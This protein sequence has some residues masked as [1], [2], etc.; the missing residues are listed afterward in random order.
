[1][2]TK[3]TCL[4]IHT[5]KND[6]G[7]F[8]V[9]IGDIKRP[10]SFDS[11]NRFWKFIVNKYDYD[12]TILKTNMSWEEACDLE[13]KMIAFYGRRDKKQGCLVNLTDGGDGTKGWV[14]NEKTLQKMRKNHHNVSGKNN[15]MFGRT[16]EKHPKFGKK[17]PEHSIKMKGKMIG[18][19][20]PNFGKKNPEHSIRMSG[21]GNPKSKKVICNITGKIYKCVRE[22]AEDNGVNYGT[23]KFY[24]RNNR[25]NKTSLR[26][27]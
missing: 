25:K 18:E 21:E 8:Y 3:D 24:L 17:Y 5:R 4:Y 9:G 16:G 6:G 1:M 12:V 7:I 26:Y 11:R 2:E 27:I 22:A 19:K 14:P 10:Y 15:P 13:I 20:N 23:L